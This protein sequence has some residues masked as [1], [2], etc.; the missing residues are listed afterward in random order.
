MLVGPEHMSYLKETIDLVF[1]AARVPDNGC[2][3]RKYTSLT[4]TGKRVVSFSA[5]PSI[6]LPVAGTTPSSGAAAALELAATVKDL[7][8][9]S[10]LGTC[11]VIALCGRQRR[12]IQYLDEYRTGARCA[13]LVF[14]LLMRVLLGDTRR[15]GCGRRLWS[16]AFGCG[17]AVEPRRI[18]ACIL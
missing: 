12:L 2:W 4:H 10:T 15:R 6:L 17:R 11:C 18:I 8:K 3:V 7:Q 9:G 1:E 5:K 16:A 13:S 14:L